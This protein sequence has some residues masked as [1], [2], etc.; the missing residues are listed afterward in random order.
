MKLRQ[1][2]DISGRISVFL[3]GATGGGITFRVDKNAWKNLHFKDFLG[4]TGVNRQIRWKWF[5][6]AWR[7]LLPTFIRSLRS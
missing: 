4:L 5:I 7:E 2:G 6:L 3:G 1:I